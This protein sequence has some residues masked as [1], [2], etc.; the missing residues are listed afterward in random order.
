MPMIHEMPPSAVLVMKAHSVCV[1]SRAEPRRN[2]LV[3]TKTMLQ[4]SNKR[5]VRTLC[6]LD[7]SDCVK[8][9]RRL[10]WRDW[11]NRSS[12]TLRCHS[13]CR[14]WMNYNVYAVHDFRMYTLSLSLLILEASTHGF[15]NLKSILKGSS[16]VTTSSFNYSSAFAIWGRVSTHCHS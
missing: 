10:V 4:S 7:L 13:L 9:M 3:H 16:V 5:F 15:R 11:S 12:Q 14:L 1:G 8:S 2:K 6:I